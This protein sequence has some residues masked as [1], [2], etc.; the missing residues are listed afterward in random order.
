MA[1]A[2]KTKI[3]T[4]LANKY[5]AGILSTWEVITWAVN[6]LIESDGVDHAAKEMKRINNKRQRQGVY[7]TIPEW[8]TPLFKAYFG[9]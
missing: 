6:A 3:E 4:V 5:G 9:K 7:N 1:N 8:G 2:T